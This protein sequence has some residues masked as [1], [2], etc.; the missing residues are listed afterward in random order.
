[1]AE[2]EG[3]PSCCSRAVA[4]MRNETLC[5][6]ATASRL[7][8]SHATVN[9]RTVE[10]TA[11]TG[12]Q[13]GGQGIAMQRPVNERRRSDRV[14]IRRV[15]PPSRREELPRRSPQPV[16]APRTSSN[17]LLSSRRE[18]PPRASSPH[19]LIGRAP[20]SV[21]RLPHVKRRPRRM[22]RRP[23]RPQRKAQTPAT[24][25]RSTVRRPPH[26]ASRSRTPTRRRPQ[27]QSRS[28]T[29]ARRPQ[30]MTRASQTTA[31]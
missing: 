31:R 26:S 28:Q 24:E 29:A 7:G 15:T 12:G 6:D 4:T 22:T 25:L 27:P 19:T 18:S 11:G 3:R 10:A 16:R 1:M 9:R 17:R 5:Y 20:H 14:R 23:P 8:V 30:R 21:R 2:S 13:V